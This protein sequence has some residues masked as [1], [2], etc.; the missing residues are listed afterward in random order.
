MIQYLKENHCIF[1]DV[2][3]LRRQLPSIDHSQE[4]KTAVI[5]LLPRACVEC[6][7][8]QNLYKWIQIV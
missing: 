4:E 5:L 8:K 7:V 2:G 3:V 6:T 1:C